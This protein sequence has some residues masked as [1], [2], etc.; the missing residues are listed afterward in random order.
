[1]VCEGKIRLAFLAYCCML[2]NRSEAEELIPGES[3]RGNQWRI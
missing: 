1:M 3:V 2:L